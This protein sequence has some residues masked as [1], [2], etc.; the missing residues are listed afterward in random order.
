M[1]LHVEVVHSLSLLYSFPLHDY[2]MTHFSFSV[3]GHLDCL[4]FLA[5]MNTAVLNAFG[6]LTYQSLSDISIGA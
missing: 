4:L 2:I 6:A 5:I 1:M 3:D